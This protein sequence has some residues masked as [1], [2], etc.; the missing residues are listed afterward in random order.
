MIYLRTI[1]FIGVTAT[2]LFLPLWVFV[3]VALVYALVFSPYELLVLGVCIDAQFGDVA[4][5]VWY[6]YT[7]VTALLTMFTMGVRPFLRFYTA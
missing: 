3:C 2:A 7:G 5:G 1:S 6:V 4:R